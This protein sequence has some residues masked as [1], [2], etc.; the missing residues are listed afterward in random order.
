MIAIDQHVLK[1]LLSV[2]GPI[3]VGE[4]NATVTS[5]NVEQ[6]MRMQKVRP[7]V[8]LQDPSWSRKQFMTPIASAVL[9]KVLSGQGLSWEQLLKAM[10]GELDQ[11]HIL[12]ELDDPV[13]SKLLTKRGWDGTVARSDGDFLMVVDTNVGYNKTNAVVSP[14]LF[15]DVDLTDP[16]KPTS[17]LKVVHNNS[18]QGPAGQCTER[19]VGTDISELDNWYPIDRCYYDYLRAYLPA[20]TQLKS[21]TPHAVSNAAMTMLDNPVPPRVDVLDES[22]QGLQGYGTLLVVPMGQSLETDFQFNLPAGILT[23][24]LKL[25]DLIY[26]LKVQKQDGT[27][28]IPIAVRVHL[29]QGSQIR[30]VSPGGSVMQS[31][32]LLFN[33]DLS[34]DI[35]IRIEFHP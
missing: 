26:Q 2:T 5:D 16:T 34:T 31:N 24:D 20:G 12:V 22:L 27:G 19:S 9:N 28:A 21:A 10:T 23:S 13:L 32:N 11:R 17:D 14:Y 15:Y 8:D 18:A 6:I 35:N 4:I 1:T 25:R 29:P 3:Y 30:T 7:N 33:L